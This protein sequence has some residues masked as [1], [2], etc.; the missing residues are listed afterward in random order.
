M[1]RKGKKTGHL[2]TTDKALKHF[3]VT[4]HKRTRGR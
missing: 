1:A 3:H 4:V 2:K